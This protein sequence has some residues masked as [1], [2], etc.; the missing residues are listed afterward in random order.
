MAWQNIG[1]IT[2]NNTW[3]FSETIP[4]DC[5]VI[6]LSGGASWARA[7][8]GFFKETSEQEIL[9]LTRFTAS[10][11]GR[12]VLVPEVK[13]SLRVGALAS[14]GRFG[15]DSVG[16]VLNFAIWVVNNNNE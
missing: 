5:Q 14:R 3:Q 15:V 11:K 4:T 10:G 7:W 2:V 12:M 13:F 1:S 8:V 6:R 16:F 9:G